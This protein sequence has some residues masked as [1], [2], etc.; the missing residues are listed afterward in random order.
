[1][2]CS[3]GC[4]QTAKCLAIKG[5]GYSAVD[6]AS[7]C[8]QAFSLLERALPVIV[9]VLLLWLCRLNCEDVLNLQDC[10][11]QDADKDYF[12]A[13]SDMY[14]WQANEAL[15]QSEQGGDADLHDC[16][17]FSSST[18]NGTFHTWPTG[19]TQTVHTSVLSSSGE[20][21][22]AHR[23]DLLCKEHLLQL[24]PHKL[25]FHQEVEGSCRLCMCQYAVK[26][27]H[28]VAAN[29]LAEVFGADADSPS[30]NRWLMICDRPYRVS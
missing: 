16:H 27:K 22:R 30:A 15:L 8:K 4:F 5:D 12:Q 10:F 17:T 1:M 13:S 19:G 9:R 18:M 2:G 28:E 7:S 26:H 21:S 29:P 3:A 25:S 20:T 6:N 14:S 11:L 23:R 24:L